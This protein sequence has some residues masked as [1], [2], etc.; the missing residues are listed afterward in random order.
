MTS[1]TLLHS[2]DI[3]GRA[4]WLM[5]PT[6]D[7]YDA[8][9]L[10][11]DWDGVWILDRGGLSCPTCICYPYDAIVSG[12]LRVVVKKDEAARYGW[13]V[14]DAPV[15][16]VPD[17]DHDIDVCDIG[18]Q[19]VPTAKAVDVEIGT[20]REGV[21]FDEV[22]RS[23]GLGWRSAWQGSARKETETDGDY[24]RGGT[25]LWRLDNGWTL[26]QRWYYGS[27]VADDWEF[28]CPEPT[29]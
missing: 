4:Q 16:T 21:V 20:R 1:Y 28:I 18:A 23:D 8:V 7:I 14:S 6:T 29:L 5:V 26:R 3:D 19:L 24:P 2:D 9:V 17:W 13:D 27:D 15:I 11:N 25:N 10:D 22:D 12:D